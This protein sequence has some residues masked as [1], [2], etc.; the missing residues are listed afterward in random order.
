MLLSMINRIYKP[1]LYEGLTDNAT[2]TDDNATDDSAIVTDDS[3]T[4]LLS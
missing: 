1:E 4:T 3:A 2:G